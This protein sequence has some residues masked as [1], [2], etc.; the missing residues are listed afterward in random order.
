MAQDH[1]ELTDETHF[2][3]SHSRLYYSPSI[4]SLNNTSSN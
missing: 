2:D 1:F 3:I 4:S